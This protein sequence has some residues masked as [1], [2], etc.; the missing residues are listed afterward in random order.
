[1]NYPLPNIVPDR[2]GAANCA[3]A[4]AVQESELIV[5][6][7]VVILSA[8]ANGQSLEALTAEVLAE[9]MLLDPQQRQVLS[10][11]VTKAWEQVPELAPLSSSMLPDRSIAITSL[12]YHPP[13]AV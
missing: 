7:Q 10:E 12:P 1:M 9:D 5:A 8:R 6:L 11:I 3:R 4:T 2:F 13:I